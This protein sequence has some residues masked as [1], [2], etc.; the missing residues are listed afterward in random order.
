MEEL[1]ERMPTGQ[2]LQ[3]IRLFNGAVTDVKG[4]LQMIPQLP[5]ELALVES[6][7]GTAEPE[8]SSQTTGRQEPAPSTPPAPPSTVPKAEGHRVAESSVPVLTP[9]PA[10][11]VPVKS[12][13]DVEPVV[14]AQ[15]SSGQLTLEMVERV[16]E[17]ILVA[18]R[19]RNP[20]AEGALRSGC[21]P[22]EVTGN[23]VVVTFPYP[24]LRDKLGDP[25]RKVEVQDALSEVVGR[26][27]HVKLVLASD[28]LPNPQAAPGPSAP[29]SDTASPQPALDAE[30]LGQITRW[31]EKLGG[32]TKVVEEP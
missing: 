4:G 6:I 10:P 30:D 31:A 20:T 19:Q 16:W 2:L 15:T 13:T 29:A 9:T 12:T 21:T 3:A 32:Q 7:M 24:F 26:S 11:H 14:E 23:Q 27:C 22:V 25:Q 5:L 1:A 17:Q 8:A 28:Y 18:V